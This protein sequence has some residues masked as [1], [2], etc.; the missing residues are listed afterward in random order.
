MIKEKEKQ[1]ELNMP[2][3]HLAVY[4]IILNSKDKHVTRASILAQLGKGSTY[5]RR[6]S[7]IVNDLVVHYKLPVGAS[8]RKDSKGY[9]IIENETDRYLAKRDL[10][11]KSQSLL[12]RYKALEEIQY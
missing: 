6:L 3:E 11:S 4:Q 12:R 8:S 2:D 10:Y 7:Q 5:G 1:K 9:F